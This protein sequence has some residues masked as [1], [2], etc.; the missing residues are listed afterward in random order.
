[1]RILHGFYEC[2]K[3]SYYDNSAYDL[4]LEVT[5]YSYMASYIL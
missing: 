4:R 1:M 3:Y 2:H 5:I